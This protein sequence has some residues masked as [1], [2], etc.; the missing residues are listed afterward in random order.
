LNQNIFKGGPHPS[1]RLDKVGGRIL[2]GEAVMLWPMKF[3]CGG[4]WIVPYPLQMY[5]GE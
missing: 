4:V 1:L 5:V 2:L 3:H